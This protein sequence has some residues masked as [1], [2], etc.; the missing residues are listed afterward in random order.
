MIVI[1]KNQTATVTH[2]SREIARFSN[3]CEVVELDNQA[4]LLEYLCGDEQTATHLK[5]V[6]GVLNA[7]V[8][9]KCDWLAGVGEWERSESFELLQGR[10]LLLKRIYD[11]DTQSYFDRLIIPYK[12]KITT[13]DFL[14]AS[15]NSSY[16][17]DFTKE[18]EISVAFCDGDNQEV[19]NVC[20][21]YNG[22][23]WD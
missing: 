14:E 18:D 21:T 2:A 1:Y 23:S 19:F 9:T 4:W 13:L 6:D 17:I 7:N 16:K 3:V 10:L 22:E 15:E 8:G 11:E 20:Y 5:M 12:G